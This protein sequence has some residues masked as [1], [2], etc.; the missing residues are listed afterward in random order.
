MTGT[1]C[2]THVII[3]AH[4]MRARAHTLVQPRHRE[5]IH[6]SRDAAARL[7]RKGRATGQSRGRKDGEKVPSAPPPP[8]ARARAIKASLQSKLSWSVTRTVSTNYAVQSRT[9]HRDRPR[10]LYVAYDLFRVALPRLLLRIRDLL[11]RAQV[12]P[13]KMQIRT[14]RANVC[15]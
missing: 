15:G 9:Q 10:N 13:W 11:E 2:V 14:I 3:H 5:R 8:R 4:G 1:R 7:R 6:F 12:A